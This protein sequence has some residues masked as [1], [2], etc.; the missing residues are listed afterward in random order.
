MN[1]DNIITLTDA[2]TGEELKLMLVDGFDIKDRNFSVFLTIEENEDD[3]EMLILEVIEA[4]GETMLSSIS[5]EEEDMVYGYYDQLVD[6][7]LADEDGEEE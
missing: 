3:A 6:D 4:D 2:E 1:D 7:A 5:E